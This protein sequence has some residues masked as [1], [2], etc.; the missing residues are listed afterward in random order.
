LLFFAPLGLDEQKIED[1]EYQD[2]GEERG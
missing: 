1:D 2:K